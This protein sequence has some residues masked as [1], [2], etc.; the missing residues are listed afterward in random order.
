[1]CCELICLDVLLLQNLLFGSLY[2]LFQLIL[3]F[4]DFTFCGVDYI[5]IFVG[6]VI[7]TKLNRW[8]ELLKVT[9]PCHICET[10]AFIIC[11]LIPE[12]LFNIFFDI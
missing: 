11:D 6:N 2:T 5:L 10:T 12:L 8:R 9:H 1:M 7:V 4:L 3:K